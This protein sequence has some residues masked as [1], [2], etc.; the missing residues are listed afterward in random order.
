MLHTSDT[1]GRE[2]EQEEVRERRCKE[3]RKESGVGTC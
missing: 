3:R 1:D 2:E